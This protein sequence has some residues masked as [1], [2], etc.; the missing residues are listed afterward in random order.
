MGA[1]VAPAHAAG[2][3]ALA[4]TDH[5]TLARVPRAIH[6]GESLGVRGVPGVEL[7]AHDGD[8]E[9]HILALHVTRLSLIEAR[10]EKF[11][12]ER[13]LRAARIVERLRSLGMEVTV[14]MVM[15]EAA[16]A[17][18]AASQ[19]A[20]RAQLA[21]ETAEEHAA[22]LQEAADQHDLVDL[23]EELDEMVDLRAGAVPA[24]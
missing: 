16:D 2:I 6:A 11:R 18:L 17:A 14:D 21:S 19:A 24:Q 1:G 20:E 3:E 13:H 9:I 22:T 10:L 8:I 23:M 12:E 7:S 15:E 4:L 5:D